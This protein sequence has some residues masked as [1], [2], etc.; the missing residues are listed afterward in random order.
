MIISAIKLFVNSTIV[1]NMP[2]EI[3]LEQ[4]ACRKPNYATL[5]NVFNELEFRGLDTRYAPK[6]QQVLL[7]AQ[8]MPNNE[9]GG[10]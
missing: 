5:A 9:A 7:V 10:I 6:V 8:I 3:Q 1:R 2:I 4:L